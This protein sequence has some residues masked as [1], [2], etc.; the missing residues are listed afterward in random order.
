MGKDLGDA[1][2]MATEWKGRI[3]QVVLHKAGRAGGLELEGRRKREDHLPDSL[4]YKGQ[5]VPR[6]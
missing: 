3:Q 2:G 6:D 1:L 5:C 4:V